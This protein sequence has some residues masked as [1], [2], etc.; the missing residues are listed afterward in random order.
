VF[1]VGLGNVAFNPGV[2]GVFVRFK[3]AGGAT[4][5]STSVAVRTQ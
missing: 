2:N 1:V 4:V 5:G 3:T